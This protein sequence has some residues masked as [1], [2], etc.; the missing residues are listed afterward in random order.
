MGSPGIFFFLPPGLG[1]IKAH[2]AEE[3]VIGISSSRR[4]AF[5]G[6]EVVE[7]PFLFGR[8]TR[9]SVTA[10]GRKKRSVGD[11]RPHAHPKFLLA[12]VSGA[13]FPHVSRHP[14]PA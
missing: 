13:R 11:F 10:A 7:V 6:H 9:A 14:P 12:D 8:G 5:G 1:S 2:H 3:V 4:T